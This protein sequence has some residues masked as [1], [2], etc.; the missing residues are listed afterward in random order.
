MS[1][2]ILHITSREAWKTAQK[3]RSIYRA[4]FDERWIYSLFDAGTSFAGR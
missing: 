2:T 1:E 4:E 3:A